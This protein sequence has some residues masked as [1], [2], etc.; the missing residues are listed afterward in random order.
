VFG[1]SSSAWETWQR[2]VSAN[3]VSVD[4]RCVNEGAR[5]ADGTICQQRAEA[6][7]WCNACW[8]EIDPTV[9]TT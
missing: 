7:G 6:R 4:A 9:P 5:R 1:G 8:S 3:A 2:A